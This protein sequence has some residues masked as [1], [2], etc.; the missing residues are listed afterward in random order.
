MASTSYFDLSRAPYGPS[1]AVT[2]CWIDEQ[3]ERSPLIRSAFSAT[4]LPTVAYDRSVSP[5]SLR[6]DEE[7]TRISAS[8]ASPPR[9]RTSSAPDS[10]SRCGVNVST[11]GPQHRSPPPAFSAWPHVPSHM[12][13][14]AQSRAP[15]QVS[16]L[17]VASLLN[18]LV[19]RQH[20]DLQQARTEAYQRERE[21][22]AEAAEREKQT[23]QREQR[24]CQREKEAKAEAYQREQ[25]ARAEAKAEAKAEVLRREKQVGSEVEKEMEIDHLRR[26]LAKKEAKE[27][28]PQLSSASH[29]VGV[30]TPSGVGPIE[31]VLVAVLNREMDRR[32]LEEEQRALEARREQQLEVDRLRR[33]SMESSEPHLEMPPTIVPE[34]SADTRPSGFTASQE[35]SVVDEYYVRGIQSPQASVISKTLGVTTSVASTP[36]VTSPGA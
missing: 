2:S 21:I 20:D 8:V 9:L 5:N 11:G 17:D 33:Q 35:R 30:P 23:D 34:S 25:A 36:D 3:R 1:M 13:S 6:C 24:T 15:S 16:G 29:L 32:R 22:K 31:E 28:Q 27:R 18:R 12:S 14:R 7:V 26:K 19:D 4:G 10:P